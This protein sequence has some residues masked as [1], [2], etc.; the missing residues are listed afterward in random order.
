MSEKK[1]TANI[2]PDNIDEWHEEDSVESEDEYIHHAKIKKIDPIS[3][4]ESFIEEMKATFEKK[5]DLSE[6]D[7]TNQT[8]TLSSLMKLDVVK[9]MLANMDKK[10]ESG[11]MDIHPFIKFIL[12]S[13]INEFNS[14][15]V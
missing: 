6:V 7:C 9:K 12:K 2:N 3:N 8:S 13:D 1:S 11:E 5:V 15:T 4:S 10:L 14:F